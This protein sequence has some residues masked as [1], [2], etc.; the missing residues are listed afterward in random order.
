MLLNRTHFPRVIAPC[1][2][3]QRCLGPGPRGVRAKQRRAM[4]GKNLEKE[5]SPNPRW[6]RPTFCL[7]MDHP[8]ELRTA[9]LPKT[10]C[11]RTRPRTRAAT[12][13]SV[14]ETK[15]LGAFFPS[16]TRLLP[17]RGP[18][19]PPCAPTPPLVPTGWPQS[20]RPRG[21]YRLGARAVEKTHAGQPLP[22]FEFLSGN[23][24]MM[25]CTRPFSGSFPRKMRCSGAKATD[26]GLDVQSSDPLCAESVPLFSIL[27]SCVGAGQ[28]SVREGVPRWRPAAVFW[29]LI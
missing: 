20:P 12:P 10:S 11:F 15:P 24:A 29:A 23:F 2:P 22:I 9:A 14:A 27:F 25:L 4:S 6:R 3:L 18:Q 13:R 17:E 19:S 28:S 7:Q 16:Q 5:K 26:C 8:T 1:G 21:N